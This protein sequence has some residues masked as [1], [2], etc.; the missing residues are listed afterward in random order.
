MGK[1]AHLARPLVT[2]AGALA[3]ELTILVM[4]SHISALAMG[5]AL[6]ILG[7]GMGACFGSIFDVALG[8]VAPEESGSASGALSAVQQVANASG[9]ALVTSI[10]F[11]ELG[12]RGGASALQLTVTVV[13]GLV[14]LCLALLPLLPR[15]AAQESH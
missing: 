2:F 7:I 4:T 14:V 13:A 12:A 5:P 6:L 15:Q 11:A 9:S 10:Y 3:L 8:N 1:E